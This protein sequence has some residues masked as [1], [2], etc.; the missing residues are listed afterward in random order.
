M[1]LTIQTGT[2]L[3][4]FCW[5]D[6]EDRSRIR[7]SVFRR[8]DH[9]VQFVDNRSSENIRQSAL[10]WAL[11]FCPLGSLLLCVLSGEAAVEKGRNKGSR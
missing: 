9:C 2:N 8:L 3:F 6:G 5:L 7:N 11:V 4:R 1:F 10:L